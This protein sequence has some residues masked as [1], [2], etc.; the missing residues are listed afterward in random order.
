MKKQTTIPANQA[1]FSTLEMWLNSES[2][3]FTTLFADKGE[4]ISRKKALAEIQMF[5]SLVI[6]LTFSFANPIITAICALWFAS[7][8]ILVKMVGCGSDKEGGE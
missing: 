6:L 5:T 2:K 8:V 4:S 7:S 3:L 1:D